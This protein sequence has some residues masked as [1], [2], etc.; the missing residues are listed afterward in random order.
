MQRTQPVAVV[1]LLVSNR[2]GHF[3]QQDKEEIKQFLDEMMTRIEME[4]IVLE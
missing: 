3:K 4:W 1:L 2:E